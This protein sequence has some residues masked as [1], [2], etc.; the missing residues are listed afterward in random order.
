MSP[1][2]QE[3]ARLLSDFSE[4]AQAANARGELHST[5]RMVRCTLDTVRPLRRLRGLTGL[6]HFETL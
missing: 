3:A 5:T 4:I 2:S 6:R 1:E